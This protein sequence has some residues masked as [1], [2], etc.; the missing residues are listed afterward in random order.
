[1]CA[2]KSTRDRNFSHRD[3]TVL[4]HRQNH[5]N[6]FTCLAFSMRVKK[7]TLLGS[8]YYLNITHGS[9]NWG[10]T[11]QALQNVAVI[12]T[13]NSI[14]KGILLST[15]HIA[16]LMLSQ[17]SRNW[18][19]TRA[20]PCGP[21]VFDR[22]IINHRMVY[23]GCCTVPFLGLIPTFRNGKDLISGSSNTW[24]VGKFK[25][26]ENQEY[27][28]WHKR[29]FQIRFIQFK[30]IFL[31]FDHNYVFLFSLA[32]RVATSSINKHGF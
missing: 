9:T 4:L 12:R 2:E 7:S 26:S 27:N 5:S 10:S 21:V 17:G 32:W 29:F 19:K 22:D 20:F 1:M 16:D 23:S 14:G 15:F 6:R 11:F 25:L 30:I 3:S 18:F 31:R 24:K 8:T 28:K 13:G